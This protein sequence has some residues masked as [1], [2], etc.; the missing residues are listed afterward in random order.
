MKAKK[1]RDSI[2]IGVILITLMSLSTLGY[3]FYSASGNSPVKGE[4]VEYA[5]I[6]FEQTTYGTWIFNIEG[7]NF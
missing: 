2:I 3:A 6:E 4:T 5:G 7:Y 1:R